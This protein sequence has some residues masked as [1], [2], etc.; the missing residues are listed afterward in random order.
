MALDPGVLFRLYTERIEL[1]NRVY[2]LA[3]F[4]SFGPFGLLPEEDRSDLEAQLTAM[5]TYLTVLNRR[6]DRYEHAA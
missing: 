1:T 4:V 3:D 2:R 5:R 6:I